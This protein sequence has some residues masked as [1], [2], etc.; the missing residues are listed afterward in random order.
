MLM[1][2]TKKRDQKC[3]YP[4]LSHTEREKEAFAR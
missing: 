1:Y 4:I 3:H 2:E